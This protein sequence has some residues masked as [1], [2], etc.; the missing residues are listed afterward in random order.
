MQVQRANP[1]KNGIKK[2]PGAKNAQNKNKTQITR[3][4]EDGARVSLNDDDA[5]QY[6]VLFLLLKAEKTVR[7]MQLGHSSN[8]RHDILHNK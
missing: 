1:Q 4:H 7:S 5:V 6:F 8:Q 2:T 3:T